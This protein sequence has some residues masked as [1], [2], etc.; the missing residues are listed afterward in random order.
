MTSPENNTEQKFTIVQPDE[1]GLSRGAWEMFQNPKLLDIYARQYGWEIIEHKKMLL[2]VKHLPAIGLLSVKTFSPEAT[3]NNDWREHLLEM[4]TGYVS[5]MSNQKDK[6]PQIKASSAE[7]TYSFI[8]DL[9][10]DEDVLLANCE[11]RSRKAFR[12]AER[13]G[14][15]VHEAQ[16]KK[17]LPQFHS[18]MMKTSNNGKLF[19]VPPLALL[20][21]L[22]ENGFG[23][24]Y[25]ASIKG[26]I[27]GGV[28]VLSD[29]YVHGLV[30]GFDIPAAGGIS[31]NLLYWESLLAEKKRNCEFFD[32]G[33]Q[34]LSENTALVK[35]KRSFAPMLVPAYHYEYYPSAWRSLAY[36][37]WNGLKQIKNNLR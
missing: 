23:R 11:R 37:G 12:H 14:L 16:S 6:H 5:V 17:E 32:F 10:Q 15:D 18:L 27:V 21:A 25:V 36:R 9:K 20:E 33:T 29:N 31:S 2:A 7:D 13:N 34:S 28:Y 8:V 1:I 30:S 22:F 35:F 3:A 4:P 19:Q 24:L 26:N